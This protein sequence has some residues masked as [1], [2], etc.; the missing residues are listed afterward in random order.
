MQVSNHLDI[1][2]GC[3]CCITIG[4]FDGLHRGHR[5]LV[6]RT[7][8]YSRALKREG[9]AKAVLIAFDSRGQS[10]LTKKERRRILEGMGVDLLIECPLGPEIFHMEAETFAENILAGRLHARQIVVGE[11]FHFG[12]GRRGTPA[13]LARV[14]RDCSFEVDPVP[15]LMD[16][17][18]KISSTVIRAELKSGHME[19]V[20]DLLGYPYFI[21]G[22]VIHG[23]ERGRTIGIPTA[24]LIPPPEKMLPPFGVYAS[25][26]SV[27]GHE[28]EGMTDIGTKPT[29]GGA[30]V[31]VETHFHHFHGNLY[32]RQMKV[33]LLHFTRPEEKFASFEELHERLLRDREVSMAY[34]HLHD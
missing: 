3:P 33:S 2:P 7:V 15:D 31:G 4:K 29:V 22:E 32:G 11:D 9:P 30:E 27:G 12:Y 18:Q 24:N 19:R 28:L 14:G 1:D 6:K 25:R 16:G 17:A 20:Q 8:G 5:E 26:S 23:N 34:F 13:L 10:L 21:S